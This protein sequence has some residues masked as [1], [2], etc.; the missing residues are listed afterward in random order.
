MA[1]L[2]HIVGARDNA[3]DRNGTFGIRCMR[4]GYQGRAAG[5][6]I[7]TELPARKIGTI[8]RFLCQ[9]QFAGIDFIY[10]ADRCRAAVDNGDL[11]GIGAGAYIQ[12][13][14]TG[15]GVPQFFD[16]IG[17]SGEPGNGNLAAGVCGMRAGNKAGAGGAGVD[18][19]FPPGQVF[20]ILRGLCQAEISNRL[21]L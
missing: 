11:L 4:A 18:P 21:R 10:E 6:G 16:V 14:N 5:I 9:S 20:A 15:I 8:V 2:L 1:N 19:E 3:I 12:S 7:N 13:L 17:A